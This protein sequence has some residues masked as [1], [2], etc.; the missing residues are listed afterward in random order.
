MLLQ[1]QK[2]NRGGIFPSPVLG[3]KTM[4]DIAKAIQSIFEA[5]TGAFSYAEASKN[6]QSETD[7][8]KCKRRLRRQE[9][10]QEDLILDMAAILNK[11][12]NTFSKADR[13]R[14]RVYLSKIKRVN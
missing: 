9:E 14:T 12:I 10:R 1:W 3:E 11:Y 6:R 8:I 2:V 4:Y 7:I 13:I 5:I